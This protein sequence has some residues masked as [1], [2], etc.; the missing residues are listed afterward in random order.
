MRPRED[1]DLRKQEKSFRWPMN[2]KKRKWL[3]M[4]G[5]VAVVFHPCF[6]INDVQ[7]SAIGTNDSMNIALRSD[8]WK[9]FD[10]AWEET[11]VAMEVEPAVE[12]LEGLY[13]RPMEKSRPS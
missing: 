6:K 13:D 5:H 3:P 1:H 12:P 10:Q 8:S 11:L 4:S 2:D 7:E 9:L